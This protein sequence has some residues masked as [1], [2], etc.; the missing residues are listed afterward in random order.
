[1]VDFCLFLLCRVWNAH[2][3]VPCMLRRLHILKDLPDLTQPAVTDLSNRVIL[4]AKSSKNRVDSGSSMNNKVKKTGLGEPGPSSNTQQT[5]EISSLCNGEVSDD[6]SSYSGKGQ[7]VFI[8][9]QFVIERSLFMLMG[10]DFLINCSLANLKI[11]VYH[12]E[13]VFQLFKPHVN[14]IQCVECISAWRRAHPK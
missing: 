4:K 5:S 12:F 8:K 13:Q 10:F 9:V 7:F 1:M 6:P 3:Q 14:S 11:E 2:T